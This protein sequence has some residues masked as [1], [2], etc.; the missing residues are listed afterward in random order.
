MYKRGRLLNE[1]M[2][3]TKDEIRRRTLYDEVSLLRFI[4]GTARW[5]KPVI[6][7][8]PARHTSRSRCRT[9]ARTYRRVMSLAVTMFAGIGWV[10]SRLNTEK[11]SAP[12]V[13]SNQPPF[14]AVWT[15]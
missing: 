5:S 13:R 15:P 12:V 1:V 2:A 8:R 10:R 3:L 4:T 7:Q 6:T 11:N 9:S 14:L